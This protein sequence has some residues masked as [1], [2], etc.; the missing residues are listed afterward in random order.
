MRLGEGQ[1]SKNSLRPGG[2]LRPSPSGPPR[3]IPP[4]PHLR[5]PPRSPT[6]RRRRE[7][8]S[9]RREGGREE[10]GAG[11]TKPRAWPGGDILIKPTLS[12][13]QKRGYSPCTQ[14]SM[15]SA[16]LVFP[17]EGIVTFTVGETE[18]RSLNYRRV[19]G[20]RNESPIRL[21]VFLL[22]MLRSPFWPRGFVGTPNWPA[23][24]PQ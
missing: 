8:R 15:A 7:Q 16:S 10:A 13:R 12:R 1:Y 4:L 14:S 20:G 22:R 18:A 2:H 17:A 9:G 19:A 3:G 24:G 11:I 6:S 5:P 21:P 23:T